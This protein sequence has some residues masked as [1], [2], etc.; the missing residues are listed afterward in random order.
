MANE[1]QEA[2][3]KAIAMVWSDDAAG[4]TKNHRQQLSQDPRAFLATHCGFTVPAGLELRV[5][6]SPEPK[7]GWSAGPQSLRPDVAELN[8]FIPAAPEMLSQQAVALS[9]YVSAGKEYP[10]STC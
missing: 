5:Q 10:H 3:M 2:W 9:S 7:L 6:S 8:L 4:K 1:W